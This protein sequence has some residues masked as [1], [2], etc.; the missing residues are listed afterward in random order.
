[1]SQFAATI[2]ESA[3][4]SLAGFAASELLE[5]RPHLIEEFGPGS[6]RAWQ[7]FFKARVDELAAALLVEDRQL[8][9]ADVAWSKALFSA[10]EVSIEDLRFSFDVLRNVLDREL[11]ASAKQA[12]HSYLE[13]AANELQSDEV[14]VQSGIDVSKPQGRIAALFLQMILEGERTRACSLIVDEVRGG[15][16]VQDAYLSILLPVTREVGRMWHAGELN[17]AEEHFATATIE[18]AM[19]QL[20]ALMQRKKRNGRTVI[21]AAAQGNQHGLPVRFIG[22][23]FEMAGW[24]VIF[25]GCDMPPRDLAQATV[26]YAA[27]LVALSVTMSRHI[28]ATRA[29]IDAI[30]SNPGG[31]QVKILVGGLALSH[32]DEGWK[33]LGADGFANSAEE[34]V[35][36]ASELVGL[37]E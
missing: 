15:L 5:Q 17:V 13:V 29:C 20:F 3:S 10:R 19:S 9:A 23:F 32:S 27:D 30:R 33:K 18:I 14:V 4:N 35:V 8:F 24:R 28:R 34:A 36:V 16:A 1:M 26:D 37:P 25:L 11:P 12:V 6:H 22:D 7:D 21:V 31:E 2:L